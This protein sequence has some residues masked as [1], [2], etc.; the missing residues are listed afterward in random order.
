MNL[1]TQSLSFMSE[2]MMHTKTHDEQR[3]ISF[4]M[5]PSAGFRTKPL[6]PWVDR[7][8]GLESNPAIMPIPF[9]WDDQDALDESSGPD[10]SDSGDEDNN[11]GDSEDESEESEHEQD[12][13]PSKKPKS[14]A[15]SKAKGTRAA[16]SKKAVVKKDKSK[17]KQKNSRTSKKGDDMIFRYPSWRAVPDS[18]HH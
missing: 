16:S 13:K 4:I 8:I 17:G 1:T 12:L 9:K 15:K 3:F 10:V 6:F 7:S 14:K 5:D 11:H 18:R 2:L